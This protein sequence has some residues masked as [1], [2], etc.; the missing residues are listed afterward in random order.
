M[1]LLVGAVY[2]IANNQAHI[3]PSVVPLAPW[4]VAFGCLFMIMAEL[5][6]FFGGKEDRRSAVKDLAYLVP[7]LLISAGLGYVAQHFLW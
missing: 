7:T 1:V 4:L 5:L 6:L 3:L 2:L